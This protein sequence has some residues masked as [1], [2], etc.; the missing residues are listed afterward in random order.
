MLCFRTPFLTNREYLVIIIVIILTEIIFVGQHHLGSSY[1]TQSKISVESPVKQ[2]KWREGN[3]LS[4]RS[5]GKNK[6]GSPLQSKLP[7]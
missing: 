1:D 4:E 6:K 7:F 2:S 3:V 5:R